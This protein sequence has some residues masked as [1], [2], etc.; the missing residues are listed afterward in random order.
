MATVAQIAAAIIMLAVVYP[1][2]LHSVFSS[3]PPF[4]KLTY[5]SMRSY[6]LIPVAVVVFA[7]YRTSAFYRKTST[8]FKRHDNVLR[9][10]L[11]AFFGESLTGLSTIRAF[12]AQERH[13]E[14]NE[15]F[16]DLENRFVV[17]LFLVPIRLLT[18]DCRTAPTSSPSATNDGWA[19]GW[20]SWAPSVSLAFLSTVSTSPF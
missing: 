3:L 12:R 8:T 5:P 13:L 10:S 4:L 19:S 11:Y 9:S 7:F 16:L 17:F 14:Q 15:A 1:F 6:F 2:V 20:S 18:Q